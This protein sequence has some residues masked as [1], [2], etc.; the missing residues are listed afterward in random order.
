[1]RDAYSKEVDLA[2]ISMKDAHP[3]YRLR[4]EDLAFFAKGS[5]LMPVSCF[6]MALC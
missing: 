2:E 5:T 1:M 6:R 4:L 3:P